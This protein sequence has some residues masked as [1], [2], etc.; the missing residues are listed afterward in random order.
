MNHDFSKCDSNESELISLINLLFSVK[1]HVFNINY[2]QNYEK[3][4]LTNILLYNNV[5]SSV[6]FYFCT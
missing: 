1:L 2:T 3:E 5:K 4:N 6:N